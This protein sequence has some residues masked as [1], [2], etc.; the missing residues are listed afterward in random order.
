M[1]QSKGSSWSRR[2]FMQFA[3][4]TLGAVAL[5]ACAMPATPAQEGAAEGAGG[6]GTAMESAGITWWN[7][8]SSATTQEIVPEIVAQFEEKEGVT[9]E[10]ELSGGPPGGGDYIEVLLARIAAGNPP[11]TITLWSPPSEFGARGSLEAIDDLMA[12]ADTATPDAF[13]GGP[14]RS[15]QWQGATYGLPASAGAGSIFINK[16]KFEEKGVSTDPAD[17]PT[18]WDGLAE[19]SAQFTEWE[20]DELKQAGIVPWANSWLKPVWSQLNGGNF[21]NTETLSY[22]IDSAANEEWLA[23]WV[24]LLESEYQGD[25]E[26]LNLFGTWD[27]VYPESAFALETSAMAIAGSWACTDAEIPFAWEVAKFPVGPS[28]TTSVTGFWPNWW[29]MPKGTPNPEAGFRFCEFFCTEGWVTWYRAIMDTPAWKDFPA[30][31][32]TQ[33]LV[34]NLGAEKALDL[35]NFYAGYLE[36]AADMWNSP[37]ENFASDT[38]DAAIDEVLHKTKTPADAL[39]AAQALIQAKLDETISS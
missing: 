25:I 1:N 32:Q 27:S 18:T 4:M 6:D 10:F 13:F 28:G 37:I 33:A 23:H 5:S 20:G 22:E 8:F 36:D 39:A 12:N 34:D 14:L 21:L 17:F 31:V 29:A 9:V 19:L 11:D 35:H 2:E 38:L 26:N 15:C 7:Q 30:D 24:N 3:G 16:A